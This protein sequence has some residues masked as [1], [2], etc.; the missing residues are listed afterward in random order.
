MNI[1][2]RISAKKVIFSKFTGI[3]FTFIKFIIIWLLQKNLHHM[4]VQGFQIMCSGTGNV[5]LTNDQTQINVFTYSVM[6]KSWRELKIRGKGK[7]F[8]EIIH[9]QKDGSMVN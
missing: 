5:T 1:S 4:Q 6:S 7:N 2:Y 3:K 8:G 9:F